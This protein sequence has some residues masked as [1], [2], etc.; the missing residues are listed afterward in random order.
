MP[1]YVYECTACA[2]RFEKFQSI[3]AA[4]VRSCPKC[5][6]KVRR[7]IGTGGG[8]LFK[9]SGFYQT[10]Y[11]SKSYTDAAKKESDLNSKPSAP[12][13]TPESPKKDK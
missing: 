5:R 8:V 9:G 6:K 7:L 2:H 3:K 1:T 4:P 10:D 11:R 12:K 13:G